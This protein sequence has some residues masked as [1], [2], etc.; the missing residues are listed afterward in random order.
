MTTKKYFAVGLKGWVQVRQAAK[1][2]K[3]TTSKAVADI[4]ETDMVWEPAKNGRPDGW[5]LRKTPKKLVLKSDLYVGGR[6]LATV[7]QKTF[8]K[9]LKLIIG[10]GKLLE[11]TQEQAK[12]II[13]KKEKM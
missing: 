4:V 7:S 12:T 8:R 3:L 5:Y 9:K 11:L 1:P 2:P 10:E 6:T 13:S